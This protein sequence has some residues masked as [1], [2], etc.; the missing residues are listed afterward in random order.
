MGKQRKK[1]WG[2]RRRIV[3]ILLC[4]FVLLYIG[5]FLW[6]TYKPLPAGTSYEGQLHRT[7]DVEMLTDL[8]FSQTESKKGM[9][10]E[11]GIF[12]EVFAMIDRAEE[13]IVADFFLYNRYY[14]EQEDFPELAEEMTEKLVQKKKENPGMPV[15]LITDPVNTGYGSYETKE[16]KELEEAGVDVVITELDPLRD[17]TPLYSGVYRIFFHWFGEKGKGWLPNPM[18]SEAPKMTARSYLKLLNVKANHRKVIAT[19][20]GV[21]VNSGNPH[22]ASG[23][24]GNVAFKADGPVIND[25][26]EAEEAVSRYSGGPKKFPRAKVKEDADG[27]YGVQY[28]TESKILDH[29]LEDIGKAGKGDEIWLGMFYIANRDV[30]G[31]LY[32]A[33]DRGAEVRLVLDPNENAFGNK[34]TG[35]PNKPVVDEML[36]ESNGKI[37]VK[38][39]NTVIGQYHTKLVY[40]KTDDIAAISSGAANMTDRALEDYNLESN[41]RIEGEPDAP[42]FKEM[43]A[44]FNRLWTNEDALFTVAAEEKLDGLSQLQRVI[45]ALQELLKLTT[46]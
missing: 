3:T 42:L 6:H 26:L 44:Y 18:A 19:E 7:D 45:Y 11:N 24:H 13:F 43:D 39:Y 36:E 21:L 14:D 20:E 27:R 2:T 15:I 37:Q 31:A 25:V 9:R 30:I 28:I 5:V 4:V 38:F 35:L 17:S 32:D 41:I 10:H 33:A 22:D 16:L 40:V 34:K 23:W 1:E 29:V 46:Y 12:D 8:T